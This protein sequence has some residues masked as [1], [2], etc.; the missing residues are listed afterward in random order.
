MSIKT[1]NNELVS[2]KNLN[3]IKNT[4]PIKMYLLLPKPRPLF[5]AYLTHVANP[6]QPKRTKFF[7][8]GRLTSNLVLENSLKAK[9]HRCCLTRNL[10]VVWHLMFLISSRSSFHS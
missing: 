3:L 1:E 5:I 10:N 8:S 4:L 6:Y 2:P 7:P 9:F